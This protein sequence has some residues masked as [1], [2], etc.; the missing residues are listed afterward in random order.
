MYRAILLLLPALAFAQQ[1][2][3]GRAT[4]VAASS[5]Y[6]RGLYDQSITGYQTTISL[7]HEVPFSKMMIARM[8]GLKGEMDKAMEALDDAA[9]FEF[10]GVAILNTDPEFA[11]IRQ[12]PRF[13]AILAKVR[14]NNQLQACTTRERRKQFHFMVGEWAVADEKGTS[15]GTDKFE[16]AEN[17]CLIKET[18]T[19]RTAGATGQSYT[20]YDRLT[21]YW[22]QVWMDPSGEDIDSYGEL[23]DEGMTFQRV[24]YNGGSKTVVQT[25]YTLM[26]DGTVQQTG[27]RALNDGDFTS[28]PTLLYTPKAP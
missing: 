27:K 9:E 16:L 3:E 6:H 14:S 10:P 23:T 8:W 25:T 20:F 21:A 2:P 24:T 15:L 18:F 7:H 12:D 5:L 11:A 17:G 1:E 19:G 28:T 22:R 4:F 13:P 26:P